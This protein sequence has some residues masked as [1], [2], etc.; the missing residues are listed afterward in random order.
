[1]PKF[2]EKIQVLKKKQYKETAILFKLTHDL[3]DKDLF[4]DIA[5]FSSLRQE[6]LRWQ[7]HPLR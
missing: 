2:N 6:L 4:I 3:E 5:K 7:W 1:M